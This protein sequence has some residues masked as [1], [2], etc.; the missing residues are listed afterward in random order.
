MT[1][2]LVAELVAQAD[3]RVSIVRDGV[4]VA[5]FPG[6]RLAEAYCFE[7]GADTVASIKGVKGVLRATKAVKTDSRVYGAARIGHGV[8]LHPAFKDTLTGWIQ[9]ICGCPGTSNNHARVSGFWTDK[10]ATCRKR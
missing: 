7:L 3:G 9:C 2:T 6:L 8:K 1:H 4:E 5:T 10:Q